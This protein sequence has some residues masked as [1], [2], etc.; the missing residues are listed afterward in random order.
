MLGGERKVNKIRNFFFGI[1]VRIVSFLRW[2][3]SGVVKCLKFEIPNEDWFLVFDVPNADKKHRWIRNLES[4][5][6]D[7]ERQLLTLQLYFKVNA[8]IYW[9]KDSAPA[10]YNLPSIV[11][12]F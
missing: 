4:Y 10:Q 2:Y 3:C 6:S 8:R 9:M 1:D 5:C 7:N 11:Y 12:L